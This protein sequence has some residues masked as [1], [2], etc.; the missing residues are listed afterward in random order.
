MFV[1]PELFWQAQLNQNCFYLHCLWTFYSIHILSFRV[2]LRLM[3]LKLLLPRLL[4]MH[5]RL[6][7]PLS[8]KLPLLSRRQLL[9]TW[10]QG[11]GKQYQTLTLTNLLHVCGDKKCT[12]VCC[13]TYSTWMYHNWFSAW[14]VSVCG[15]FKTWLLCVLYWVDIYFFE[16][17]YS[18]LVLRLFLL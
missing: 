9:V 5:F 15:F 7:W 16:D 4:G 10:P 6:R 13:D 17:S 12:F 1:S 11:K 14:L 8:H 2:C 3:L 18:V